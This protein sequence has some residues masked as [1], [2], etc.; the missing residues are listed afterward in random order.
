[1]SIFSTETQKIVDAHKNDFT[2][3][4]FDAY[5]K[6]VGGYEKYVKSLGGLFKKYYGVTSRV[7]TAQEFKDR[8]EY[9]MGL[10]CIWGV[11]YWN[12][13]VRHYWGANA[14]GGKHSSDAFRQG[15][16]NVKAYK[17]TIDLDLKDKK[18][19]STNC[20]AGVDMI[21][22]ACGLYDHS[23]CLFKKEGRENTVVTDRKNLQVGDHVHFFSK[24]LTSTNPST[25]D[26][27]KHV[28]I[29][30]E[31]TDSTITFY[32][33]GNRFVRNRN[34]KWTF[35]RTS[36]KYTTSMGGTYSGYKG[37]IGIHF[38]DR[39]FTS[40][41]SRTT[42]GKTSAD[43]AVEIIAGVWGVLPE[44]KTALGSSYNAAQALV[45]TYLT[46]AGHEAYIRACAFYV[47]KGFAGNDDERKVFFGDVYDEVQDKV[48]DVIA[49]AQSVIRGY[50]GNDP[51]RK[52]KLGDDYEIVQYRVNQVL[53]G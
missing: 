45:N 41:P 2:Y 27:W 33:F 7:K 38:K 50:Y 43:L 18:Y 36:L 19:A 32:D 44:R 26:G 49:I 51:E 11:D 12:G 46:D 29:V 1:M 34:P 25:W 40:T 10:L 37:W 42:S 3:D 48:N 47:L 6:K 22:R 23:S 9:V 31:V 30:G 52:E 5:M 21:Q 39:N 20:N 8:A 13:S 17:S 16:Q 15:S 24:K 53:E 28:S 4:T 14:T 35:P